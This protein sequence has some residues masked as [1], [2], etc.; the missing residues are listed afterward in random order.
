MPFYRIQ[1]MNVNS[2]YTNGVKMPVYES[3]RLL[4]LDG[5]FD[6]GMNTFALLIL[7]NNNPF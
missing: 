6:S 7:I 2:V 5:E 4:L 1:D 3:L